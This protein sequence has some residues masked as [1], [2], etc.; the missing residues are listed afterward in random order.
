MNCPVPV[1][2]HFVRAS[3]TG[4]VPPEVMAAP[5][6]PNHSSFHPSGSG[7]SPSNSYRELLRVVHGGGGEIRTR[8]PKHQIKSFYMFIPLFYLADGTST[9]GISGSKPLRISSRPPRA[10]K[11]RDYPVNDV[12]PA[13]QAKTGRRAAL[14]R[15]Q[16]LPVEQLL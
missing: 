1:G 2:T 5:Y 14:F 10:K 11:K 8:V 9:D 3:G 6:T 16:R 12:L 13:P 7:R 4:H 15:G